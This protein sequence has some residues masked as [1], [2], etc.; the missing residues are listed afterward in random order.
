MYSK[1]SGK[2]FY[3]MFA[4]VFIVFTLKAPYSFVKADEPADYSQNF[5]D[6]NSVREDFEAY[7]KIT[8][9]VPSEKTGIGDNN[10]DDANWFV[11]DGLIVRKSK[12]DDIYED[13]GTE[14]IAILTLSKRK[15]INFELTVDYKMGEATVYWPVIAFRQSQKGRY[16]LEDGAG[17]FVQ[18][19]GIVTLWGGEGIGGPYEMP[20]TSYDYRIW[21]TLH[22]KADGLNVSVSI[23]DNEAQ[24]LLWTLNSN[25][26]KKGY[27]SLISVNN[28]CAFRNLKI[29]ELPTVDIRDKTKNPPLPE[30]SSSDA[31]SKAGEKDRKSVV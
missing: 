3:I 11:Q 1:N 14:S 8:M 20:V 18:K 30:S 12:D 13:F 19:E 21:H 29:K 25:M 27:I 28:D 31:L 5:S 6:I 9:G 26:F 17:A 22:V 2:M 16:F 23:D 24:K 7:Y 10:S 15:F 4:F